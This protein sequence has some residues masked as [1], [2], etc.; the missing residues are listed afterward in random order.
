MGRTVAGNEF[1]APEIGCGGPAVYIRSNADRPP[2]NFI[3]IHP[4]LLQ[5]HAMDSSMDNP[6]NPATIPGNADVEW[7]YV[8]VQTTKQNG[9]NKA[10]EYL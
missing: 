7:K 10:P 6:V 2:F 8:Q 4:S 3:R 9:S 5:P 1:D